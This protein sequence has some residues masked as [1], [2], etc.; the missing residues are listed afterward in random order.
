MKRHLGCSVLLLA[1]G[2][3][4][5]A[6][7]TPAP[8]AASKEPERGG[9]AAQPRNATKKGNGGPGGA[10][11]GPQRP[12]DAP[13]D[14]VRFLFK[15]DVPAHPVDLLLG[16][17][18][19]NSVTASI[20]AYEE[21]E[22]LI[23]FTPGTSPATPPQ[24]TRPFTLKPGT[25][26][27]VVL[28]GLPADAPCR[29]RLLTRRPGAK[30]W[31]PGPEHTFHTQRKAGSP[32]SF[33][34]QADPHLDYNTDPALYLRCLANARGDQPD[35]HIDL[36]DT[37]MTDKHRGRETAAAQYVAQRYYFNHIAAGAPLFLVLGN[38]DA[39]AGRWLD[40]SP[41]NLAVWANQQRKRLYP[42]PI[43][44]AFYAGN[45]TPDPQ[46]GIL[47][48]YYAWE[49]GDALFIALDPFWF[50]QRQRGGEDNWTRTLGRQQYDWLA[51]TLSKSKAS[52]RFVF[53]HHLVG[54]IGKDARG[55]AEAARLYEWGGQE[56]DG[57]AVFAAKRPGWAMPIHQLLLKHRVNVVFHGHDHLYVKQ[58]LDGVVYQEVPQPGHARYDN[59]RSAEE[60]GYKSGTIQ[61]SSGH[62]RVSVRP[63]KAV[64]EYVRAYLPSD[65]G[66]ARVNGTVSDRYEVV[67][68]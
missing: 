37:F 52:L 4:C 10:R 19:A 56:P 23:Q 47:Q 31:E 9:G 55:G 20:L 68:R 3:R 44:D 6:A 33:T 8:D 24:E 12:Q 58:D 57:T 64:V 67:A 36:G 32:F 54:G 45:T 21:R 5:L 35:F 29:Y 46:A 30:P 60:Y 43:P 41:D 17:P 39:E 38:H 15:T 26:A 63:G 59:T 51:S 27:E 2:L 22:G 49:W 11:G 18:T 14:D 40:G 16:R 61:G 62:L 7:Q 25:P 34:L 42:N 1:I 65:E 48:N 50:T 28:S 66:A 53:L 13:L